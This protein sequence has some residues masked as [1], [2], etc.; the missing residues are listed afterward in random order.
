MPN[1]IREVRKSRGLTMKQLG[2]EIGVT[3][4]AISQYETDKRQP[5]S[6]TLLKLS[7]LFDVSVDYLLGAAT[8]KKEQAP[9]IDESLSDAVSM[10]LL[11]MIRDASEEERRDM[12]DLLRI[13]QKR[14]E[15]E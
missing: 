3:E 12:L 2:K 13:V 15:K 7:N 8:D 14:R 4:S 5:D 6:V 10:E 1:R 9:A 11:N